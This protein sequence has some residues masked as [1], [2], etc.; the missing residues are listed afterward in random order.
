MMSEKTQLKNDPNVRESSISIPVWK[1]GKWVVRKEIYESRFIPRPIPTWSRSKKVRTEYVSLESLGISK[2]IKS[3]VIVVRKRENEWMDEETIYFVIPIKATVPDHKNYDHL[4]LSVS[5]SFWIGPEESRQFMNVGRIHIN[6]LN[7]KTSQPLDFG[8]PLIERVG[9][10]K[11]VEAK[12]AIALILSG[13]ALAFVG[14][15][16]HSKSGLKT[17]LSP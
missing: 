5:S 10:R 15:D 13:E 3:K 7:L 4:F 17:I 6:D 2:T 9:K 8:D 1:D 14:I 11:I 12:E 16:S